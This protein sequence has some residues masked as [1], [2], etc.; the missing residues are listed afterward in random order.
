MH[1]GL[2]LVRA[3]HD[4]KPVAMM[5]MPLAFAYF[6]SQRPYTY[7]DVTLTNMKI[8]FIHLASKPGHWTQATSAQTKHHKPAWMHRF[9][10]AVEGTNLQAV[11]ATL[12]AQGAKTTSNDIMEIWKYLGIEAARYV[13]MSEI[14][15]VMRAYGMTIDARHTMLMADCMTSKV[16]C[17][18]PHSYTAPAPYPCLVKLE[19]CTC[20]NS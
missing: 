20:D 7:P 2:V 8:D 17:S 16:P 3:S 18:A 4:H 13:I 14:K 5:V 10:L 15:E 9:T 6:A 19:P 12:G 1:K 11:M